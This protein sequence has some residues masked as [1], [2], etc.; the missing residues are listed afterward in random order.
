[1]HSS[2]YSLS[3]WTHGLSMR[4]EFRCGSDELAKSNSSWL[5][6]LNQVIWHAKVKGTHSFH[7]LCRHLVYFAAARNIHEPLHYG[8]LD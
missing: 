7:D 8:V 2:T 6:T 4:G 1:M 5:W 3:P